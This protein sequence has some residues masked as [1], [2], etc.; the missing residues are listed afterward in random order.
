MRLEDWYEVTKRE[1][2]RRHRFAAFA[3]SVCEIAGCFAELVCMVL[4]L[5][6]ICATADCFIG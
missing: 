5:W 4:L 1:N 6:L 3:D 2:E